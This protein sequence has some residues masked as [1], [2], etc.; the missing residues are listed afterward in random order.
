MSQPIPDRQS[1][2][3]D[4]LLKDTNVG[5]DLT[6][7]PVQNIIQ[8][9]II[10][11]LL[12]VV[13]QRKLNKNSPYQGMKRF[14]F[15]DR[16]RFF[17]RDKLIA[18][19]FEAVNRSNLSLVLG[20][21]GSGK[22][23]VVRAGLIPELKKS[24]E[25][26]KFYDF[27][28]TPNQDPFDSLYRCLLSEEKDYNFS[29]IE[30]E[31]ILEAKADSWTK[32]IS[33]LKK[34]D[35]RWLI[36][37]DQ[38][39]ELFTY[40][41][42]EK[43]KNFI[44][45]IVKTANSGDSSVKIVLAM[46]ADFLEDLSAYP[47]LGAI[48]NQ[49][50]IHLV[51]EMYSDELREAIEQPAA[52]HGVVFEEGLVEQIIK[53]VEGQK[54]FLPLLQYTLN[55]L[56]E[57]ECQT[58]AADGRPHIEDR[59]LNKTS[60]AALEGVRGALQKHINQIYQNLNQDE[61]TAT[62]QV[63]LKLVNIIETDSGSKIV[64]R[65]AYRDEFVS[66]SVNKTLN[67]FID[68]KLLVSSSDSTTE[69]EKV[70]VSKNSLLK[71]SA[72][73]EIAHEIL[74][75][76]WD[77]LKGWFEQEKE[78]IIIKNWLASETRRWQKI[79]LENES[80]AN[81]EL[82]KGSRL[83]QVVEF[84]NKNAFENIGGLRPEENQFIDISVEQQERQQKEK[85]RLRQRIMLG[86][87]AGFI[88][89]LSLSGFA[90]WQWRQAEI[91]KSDVMARSA[92]ILLSQGRELDA[93]M[94]SFRAV[95]SRQHLNVK[96]SIEL[97]NVLQQAVLEGRERNRLETH[98]D[99]VVSV[100][101]SPD[102]KTLASGSLDNTIK[103]WD[104]TTGKE[105]RT[106]KGHSKAVVSVSL[107]P[108]GKTLASGSYDKTIKLWDVTTGKEIRTIKGHSKSVRSVSF[109]PDGKTLASGSWDNTIK[110][111]D[112]TTGKEIRT[113]KGHSSGV[114]SV[115]FSPDGKTLASGS[116]DKTI[117]LWDVTT[118]KEIR[119]L[120]GHSSGVLSVSFSPDGKTLASGSQDKTI[121][122]WDVTTGKEIRTIKGHSS[123]VWSVSFSPDGKT[124]ASGSEDKTIKLWDVTTGKEIRT[125]K[126]HSSGVLSVSFSPDGK[127]LASGSEDNTIK[128]WD[129][130]TGK[131]IRSLKGHSSG[132]LSVSFS[133][134]GKTLA[135]GSQDKTIK[136]WD[137]TTGKEIR[138]LQGH[139]SGVLSVSFSPDGKTLAS[140]SQDKTI[141]L[142]DVTTGKEIRTLK[143]H[144]SVVW[145]VSFSPD[146][147]TLASGSED[148][149]IK[150][151]DVTT[152]KEIRTLQGHNNW[153]LSVS[154][155]P[156]GKTLASG[157]ED[158]T[159]KLWDVTTGKEIRTIKGHNNWVNSV[160]FSPD[161]KTLA[162]GSEDKTIK[163]WDVTT[164][165]EIRTIKGHSSGV[166]SVS[167]SPDGKTLA[168]GSQ[169]ETI[170][171][172][173]V[174]TGKEIRTIK[175]H[176]NWVR[177]V[178]FSP[179]GKT[180]ASGGGDKTVMLWD[181]NFEN[182]L[183]RGCDKVRVY[184]HNPSANLSESDRHLCDGIGTEK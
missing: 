76:S 98:S 178:S 68:E 72:S 123:G 138:T 20:A 104:V 176:N 154:F 127:T 60:Y 160:S 129:V 87:S 161:G 174:T 32:M 94:E 137:V 25:S 23:S 1:Q 11:S 7:A 73:I 75:S 69:T 43:C 31:I 126:G 120:K 9:Q 58:I 40:N 148:N 144:S 112:V 165:K 170:K 95:V 159:I 93:L 27:I 61:Q 46:R 145:S 99:A 100:S 56:W 181:V 150:L 173:D 121:K 84:R 162:S 79:R 153:V 146:G 125:I 172:W 124:L 131:E 179:D 115:S 119:S 103:L 13:T 64:S 16:E 35:E 29:K 4:N 30:A 19:L 3:Q 164:G 18:R 117:K 107:S 140:G 184:L 66:E 78:A 180:L 142:W 2:E 83:V 168:S 171:L 42:P 166:L 53:E 141:K 105:I 167:F 48:A 136:L 85:E 38:F 132:V 15:K 106:L 133:P 143:G 149:T 135:S 88:G 101:L 122:L 44:E 152:G 22:S 156:D 59:T 49:N 97:L 45:G 102:G 8:T 47:D 77:V 67:R 63:F 62:K 80:K 163:L 41:E 118:G 81:D 65:R 33:T 74:L 70:V 111:W 157:S 182:L 28:F 155:S 134:D 39:E 110:L 108:D 89:A 54:G 139:S 109:S 86:L 14:N 92:E 34:K 21:S 36:F 147:K 169:D 151:W 50:N 26:E 57:T 116:E 5:R 51:T 90:G 130:T 177:S 37:V 113:I 96:P 82:L 114:L 12:E 71:Q 10:Q 52:R 128:L 91:T 6:F 55:L 158:K 24:L 183:E 175:G 17:G